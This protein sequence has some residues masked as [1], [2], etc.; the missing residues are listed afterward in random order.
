[1]HKT[2]MQACIGMHSRHMQY[3]YADPVKYCCGCLVSL[4]KMAVGLYPLLHWPPNHKRQWAAAETEEHSGIHGLAEEGLRKWVDR[5]PV[6][7]TGTATESV[8]V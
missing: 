2:Y 4:H 6:Y 8:D 7:V 5:G 1:M 3:T